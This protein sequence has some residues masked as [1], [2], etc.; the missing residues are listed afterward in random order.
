MADAQLGLDSAR[1]PQFGQRIFRQEKCRLGDRGFAQRGGGLGLAQVLAK[2]QG[3]QIAPQT[4]CEIGRAFV[5]P[6]G[7]GSIRL[8]KTRPHARILRAL[9]G[10]EEDDLRSLFS[11]GFWRRD[12]AQVLDCS[13]TIRRGNRMAPWEGPA[14]LLQGP[15]D[16]GKV[17][18]VAGVQSVGQFPGHLHQRFGRLG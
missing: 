15:G 1:L 9:T 16:V 3:P 4:V 6:V 18:R 14:P 11:R 5:D 13:G 2:D 17:Q 10:E 7:V 12:V 8:V